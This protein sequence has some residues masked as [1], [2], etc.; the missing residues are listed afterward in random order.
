MIPTATTIT[1]ADRKR[2]KALQ[3]TAEILEY[4]QAMPIY[5]TL[6]HLLRDKGNLG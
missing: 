2:S 3:F 1:R 6:G 5:I 4:D